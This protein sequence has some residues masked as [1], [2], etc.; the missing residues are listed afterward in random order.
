MHVEM[1]AR[2]YL[3]HWHS[4]VTQAF[5][6]Q[7]LHVQDKFAFLPVIYLHSSTVKGKR[8]CDKESTQLVL[9]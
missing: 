1:T 3:S 2:P 6:E 7:G 5:T 9:Q 4:E 8:I